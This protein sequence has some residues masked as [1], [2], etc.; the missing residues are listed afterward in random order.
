M[1][2]VEGK[3]ISQKETS[4]PGLMTAYGRENGKGMR[5]ATTTRK[6]T[7]TRGE[8]KNGGH[9]AAPRSAYDRIVATSRLPQLLRDT[10]RIIVRPK[11]GLNVAKV[12]EI[13]FEQALAMAAALAAAEIEEDTICPN[14]TQNIYVVCTPHEK[15]A[16]AY[17]K[18]QQVRLGESTYRI[19]VY[20]APPD[21]TCKGVIRGVDVGINEAQLRARIV[22]CRNPGA[23]EAKRIK[24]TTVVVYCSRV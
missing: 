23:I 24:N 8:R 7:P 19:S 5:A 10:Y 11:D 4:S 20:P 14:G 18:A 16:R 17:V 2:I 9:N 12:S 21:D 6:G 1:E 22:N 15:N 13:C 3:D